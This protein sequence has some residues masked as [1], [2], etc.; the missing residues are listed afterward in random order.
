MGVDFLKRVGKSFHRALDR[1]AVALRTP[2]LLDADVTC[3]NRTA[4][5]SIQKQAKLEQNERVIVRDIEGR[6]V[7]QRGNEVVLVFDKPPA[8]YAAH[9]RKGAGVAIGE[10]TVVHPISQTAE[11]SICE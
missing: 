11:V 10:I 2:S 3:V 7:A 8:D 6:L 4:R 9:V 1:G 5:G